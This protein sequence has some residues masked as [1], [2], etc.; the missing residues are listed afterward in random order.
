MRVVAA[1][2]T[3]MSSS[4][5][6][7]QTVNL[8]HTVTPGKQSSTVCCNR[9]FNNGLMHMI[10]MNNQHSNHNMSQPMH[11]PHPMRVDKIKLHTCPCTGIIL[12]CMPPPLHTA[13]PLAL[14]DSVSSQFSTSPST[15]N[16]PVVDV[17]PS[18]FLLLLMMMTCLIAACCNK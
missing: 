11:L 2:F 6:C 4:Q 18:S 10:A 17:V 1:L 7:Q 8:M 12:H 14:S 16:F 15:G 5:H 13:K 3:N 9:F